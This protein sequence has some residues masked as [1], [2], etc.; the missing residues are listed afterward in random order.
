MPPPSVFD[1][2]H[3][4][5]TVGGF[6]RDLAP[7]ICTCKTFYEDGNLLL[8]L[9]REIYHERLGFRGADTR[10]SHA[11]SV[12]NL[13]RV[14]ALL[15]AHAAPDGAPL[16]AAPSVR[17]HSPLG[18]ALE[19][20]HV[21]IARELISRGA[22]VRRAFLGQHG[23]LARRARADFAAVGG[24]DRA[25]FCA[26][27]RE[28]SRLND[29]AAAWNALLTALG[30]LDA[31]MVREFAAAGIA[32]FCADAEGAR[33]PGEALRAAFGRLSMAGPWTKDAGFSPAMRAFLCALPSNPLPYDIQLLI[34]RLIA[35]EDA[36]ALPL[37]RDMCSSPLA[38][39]HVSL[40][41]IVASGAGQY[42]LVKDF[43][44]RGA[45]PQLRVTLLAGDCAGSC[46]AVLAAGLGRHR[47]VVERLALIPGVNDSD[48]LKAAAMCGSP[49]LVARRIQ[50]GNIHISAM[51]DPADET[52]LDLALRS[53]NFGAVGVLCG[54][55]ANITCWNVAQLALLWA[56]AEGAR[57]EEDIK[58]TLRLL[59]HWARNSG[60]ADTAAKVTSY[61]LLVASTMDPA[62]L[63]HLLD[64]EGADSLSVIS[65]DI[66]AGEDQ[67]YG[68]GAHTEAACLSFNAL[69]YCVMRTPARSEAAAC[70]AIS[71]LCDASGG[72]LLEARITAVV[73]FA[74]WAQDA[75]KP[76]H[77]PQA[78]EGFTPLMLA[79]ALGRDAFVECLC[80][81]GADVNARCALGRSAL[82]YANLLGFR[83]TAG[84]LLSKGAT[85]E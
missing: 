42:D 85:H 4:V 3:I 33:E 32:E 69:H 60:F 8:G 64:E 5:A 31:D 7:L 38:A 16:P 43:L 74:Q 54:F 9:S 10:L 46:T 73:H 47:D 62:L 48:A 82:H 66:I 76:E 53:R 67:H 55:R 23:F 79:A 13:S 57:C 37:L 75:P 24:A 65:E 72:R 11:V 17:A 51:E 22:S 63:R 29:G 34:V 14:R 2:A 20:F 41:L 58:S 35:L 71:A 25:A 19:L 44:A 39:G 12:N 36:E 21:D 27:A 15:D 49:A 40:A 45:N 70:A 6:G 80:A 28:V 78:Y 26:L 50:M 1:V 84:L 59:V 81:R 18:L 83:T 56:S 68:A 61:G 30:G 77:F 52:T